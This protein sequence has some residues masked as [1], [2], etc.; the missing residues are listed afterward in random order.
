MDSKPIVLTKE[1]DDLFVLR[2]WL[3]SIANKQG[4]E[5]MVIG[6]IDKFEAFVHGPKDETI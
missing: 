2:R 3:Q 1:H 5:T 4:V 6:S